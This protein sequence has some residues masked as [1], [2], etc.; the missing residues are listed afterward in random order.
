MD[1]EFALIDPGPTSLDIVP[2]GIGVGT[3]EMWRNRQHS[4]DDC[5]VCGRPLAEG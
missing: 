5:I 1:T 2:D 4:V 3:D